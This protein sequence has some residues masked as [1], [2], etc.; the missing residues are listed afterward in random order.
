MLQ[1]TVR[2]A[3]HCN[4][5]RH[6]KRGDL[7][8][9]M[10]MPGKSIMWKWRYATEK[11]DLKCAYTSYKT[12][13]KRHPIRGTIMQI[14]SEMA[15]YTGVTVDKLLDKT[16]E[17]GYNK[18]IANPNSVA[19]KD[20]I[21][22]AKLKTQ[23]DQFQEKSDML[24]QILQQYMSGEAAGNVLEVAEEGVIAENADT[25]ELIIGHSQG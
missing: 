25:P 7:E 6:E 20:S 2:D 11:L 17:A 5:C 15:P 24:K 21:D 12:H 22:A 9:T 3:P 10:L 16:I 14:D 1:S 19:I 23:K 18:L 13:F 8:K 4:I